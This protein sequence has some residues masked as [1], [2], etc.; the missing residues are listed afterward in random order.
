MRRFVFCAGLTL[1]LAAVGCNTGGHST[2]VARD[3][4]P[5]DDAWFQEEVVNSN[6]PVLV[7]FGA[8][9]CGPCRQLAP[10]LEQLEQKHGGQLK[11]VAIDVDEK[12]ELASHYQVQGIPHMLI[13]DGGKIV[14]EEVGSMEYTSLERWALGAI[15]K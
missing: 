4:T 7:D 12:P 9:W 6:V 10:R 15:K 1:A 14:A 13:L 5:P 8:T 2:G 3:I 11:I